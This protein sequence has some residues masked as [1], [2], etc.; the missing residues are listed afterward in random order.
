MLSLVLNNQ[1][2]GFLVIFIPEF[3][4]TSTEKSIVLLFNQQSFPKDFY[5]TLQ[6]FTNVYLGE[7]AYKLQSLLSNPIVYLLC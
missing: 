2:Q 4:Q 6:M 7:D 5:E 3:Y 1:A